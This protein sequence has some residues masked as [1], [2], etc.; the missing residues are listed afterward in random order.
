MLYAES[1]AI[2][3][4]VRFYFHFLHSELTE[5]KTFTGITLAQSWYPVVRLHGLKQIYV[6]HC[7]NVPN[8][9]TTVV[10]NRNM[11][12]VNRY[13]LYYIIILGI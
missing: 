12:F 8:R 1:F 6:Q 2:T 4:S 9:D 3:P 5:I 10:S 7:E 11:H 13:S